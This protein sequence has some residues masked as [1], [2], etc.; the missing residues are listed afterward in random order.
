MFFFRNTN[1]MSIALLDHV[2]K[3]ENKSSDKNDRNKQT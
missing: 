1:N 3:F 2:E